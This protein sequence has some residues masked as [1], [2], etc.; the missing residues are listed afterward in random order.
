MHERGSQSKCLEDVRSS[1]NSR[2]KVDGDATGS[3][4]DALGKGVQSG[5]RRVELPSAV[6]RDDDAVDPVS[7][8][9]VSVL[10]RV[11]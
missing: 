1:S 2:V 3:S 4:L 5:R 11:D 10:C 7:D 6:V 9:E 8:G